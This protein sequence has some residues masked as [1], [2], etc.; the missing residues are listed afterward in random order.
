[1]KSS[2]LDTE[3]L[4]LLFCSDDSRNLEGLYKAK[5]THETIGLRG[6]LGLSVSWWSESFW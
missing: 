6:S 1:M 4:P 3:V 5:P 2:E